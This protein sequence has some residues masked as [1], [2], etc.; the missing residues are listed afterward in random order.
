MPGDRSTL[1]RLAI[2]RIAFGIAHLKECAC[3]MPALPRLRCSIHQVDES[4]LGGADVKARFFPELADPGLSVRFSGLDLASGGT[5]RTIPVPRAISQEQQERVRSTHEDVDVSDR[6]W[7]DFRHATEPTNALMMNAPWAGRRADQEPPGADP[8]A[9]PRPPHDP[10]DYPIRSARSAVH[11]RGASSE[12][13]QARR[14]LFARNTI[15]SFRRCVSWVYE[16]TGGMRVHTVSSVL[17]ADRDE[18]LTT[19]EAARILNT[20]RQHVVDL[21][22]RGDLPFVTT[23]SHRRVRRADVEALRT[24]TQRLTRDQ[25]RSLWLG[26]A[27]AGKLVADPSEVLEKARKNLALLERVHSGGSSSR[28]LAEWERLLDGPEEGVLEVLTSRTPRAR[29]L[30][31]NSPFAGVL[32]EEERRAVL[33]A[34][35]DARRTHS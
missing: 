34:F 8:D 11:H 24:R 29:E 31:Q 27:I 22:G 7:L 26:Y 20:S 18:L 35:A 10:S 12:L 13:A 15:C 30:R 28:W 5:P 33:S 17:A 6:R 3:P 14:A 2:E 23:G 16:Y 9:A 4:Q 25:N 32:T 19:G 21:C 1:R